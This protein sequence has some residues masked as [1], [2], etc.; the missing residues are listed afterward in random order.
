MA[1]KTKK[2]K[3]RYSQIL[4]LIQAGGRREHFEES[5]HLVRRKDERAVEI[6]ALLQEVGKPFDSRSRA[7]CA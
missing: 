3:K 6:P 1:G 2:N 4:H 5:D 7:S